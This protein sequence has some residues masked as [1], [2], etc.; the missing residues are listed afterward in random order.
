MNEELINVQNFVY[1]LWTGFKQQD[2]ENIIEYGRIKGW[3]EDEDERF[4]QNPLTR[5][6]AARIIHQFCKIELGVPDS[7]DISSAEKLKD[8]YTCRACVNH[9]AQVYVKGIFESRETEYNGTVV[10]IFDHL[11]MVTKNE[12]IKIIEKIKRII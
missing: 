1:E 9:I 7:A 2:D 11:G 12:S 4:T 10:Q 8:L 3:L 6:T 5:R